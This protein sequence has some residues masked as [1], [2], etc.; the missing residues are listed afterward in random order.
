MD[1]AL[2]W[3]WEALDSVVCC[4]IDFLCDLIYMHLGQKLHAR[5]R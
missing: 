3:I 5:R 1:R 4:T 2:A